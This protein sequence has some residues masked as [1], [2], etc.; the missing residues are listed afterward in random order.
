ML[1]ALFVWI[2]PATVA[3]TVVAVVVAIPTLAWQW[4]WFVWLPLAP[5]L[6]LGWLV[7]FLAVCGRSI[8]R[9]H[10]R[11]PKPRIAMIP[12]DNAKMA[13]VV[14]S[15]ARRV[16]VFSLPLAPL[17]AQKLVLRAYSP[18]L[19]IGKGAQIFGLLSDPELTEVGEGVV[20][21]ADAL[22]AAH[23]RTALPNGK[24][25]YFSSPV[26]IGARATVGGGT[27]VSFGCVIGEDALI[28]P[29]SYLPPNTEVPAGEI[30]GGRP[31]TFQSKRARV[32]KGNDAA[33]RTG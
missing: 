32:R 21:G 7:V 4:P 2:W 17:V 15:S 12:G 29:M 18:S 10:A 23:A 8:R 30:W 25:V 20:I 28:E 5:L 1:V 14:L 22:I 24:T 16:V 9:V 33:D 3:G 11:H 6:Y 27:L 13:T 31:A 19:R 26:K